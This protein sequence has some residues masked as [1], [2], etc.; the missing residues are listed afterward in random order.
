LQHGL[1]TTRLQQGHGRQLNGDSTGCG[2][3]QRRRGAAV[4]LGD[5]GAV[6]VVARQWK[7]GAVI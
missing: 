1:G 4:D 5:S 7:S 2:E 6:K 3:R